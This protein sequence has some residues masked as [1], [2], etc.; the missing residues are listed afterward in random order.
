MN[1]G[2]ELPVGRQGS[3]RGRSK[4]THSA[5]C[6]HIGTLFDELF[7][8]GGVPS[9]QRCEDGHREGQSDEFSQDRKTEMRLLFAGGLLW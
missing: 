6:V 8:L 2:Q 4:R 7:Q 1:N 3:S 5:N 9:A